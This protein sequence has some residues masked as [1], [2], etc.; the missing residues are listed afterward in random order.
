MWIPQCYFL[1]K[2]IRDI[3]SLN[4]K[5]ESLNQSMKLSTFQVIGSHIFSNYSWK[6]DITVI[7]CTKINVLMYW[8]SCKPNLSM[9]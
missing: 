8:D 7:V 2:D 4:R 6:E 3:L 1:K 5:S 9:P